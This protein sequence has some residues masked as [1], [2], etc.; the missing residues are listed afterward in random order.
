[1]TDDKAFPRVHESGSNRYGHSECRTLKT[2]QGIT[3]SSRYGYTLKA[4]PHYKDDRPHWYWL[5]G[6]PCARHQD[7][8]RRGILAPL[9][10]SSYWPSF[11]PVNQPPAPTEQEFGLAPQPMYRTRIGQSCSSY[12]TAYVITANSNPHHKNPEQNRFWAS[13]IQAT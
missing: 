6:F 4:V 7:V 13:L 8:W 12:P 2:F 11:H 3:R 10:L 9:I 5:G 1:M